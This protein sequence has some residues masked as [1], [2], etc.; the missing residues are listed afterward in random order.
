MPQA[1]DEAGNIWEVDAQGNAVRLVEP[2]PSQGQIYTLPQSAKEIAAETRQEARESRAERAEDRQASND[3][4][5][6]Q[7]KAIEIEMKRQELA[8]G[9]QSPAA[10]AEKRDRVSRL[11]Q[12]VGQ[13]NRVQELYD[14]SIGT[15]KG[16]EG[17]ADYLPLDDNKR[18]DAAGA[19]LSQQG[20]AAFRVPGTGTV[21]DRDA[22]MFDRANLPTASTRDAAIEEQLLGLRNRVEAEM[23]SLGLDAPQWE[24][25]PTEPETD[26]TS[27]RLTPWD[28]SN[29]PPGPDETIA[30][31]P[32]RNVRDDR[33]SA[34]IDAMINAGASE[35]T[36]NA[37][38]KQQGFASLPL[39][40]LSAAR[41]WMKQN[42]GKAYYGANATK[43]EDLPFLSRIAGSD[44][45][46]FA[47]N[48]ANSAT[49]GTAAALAGDQGR[50]AIDAMQAVNPNASL[51]GNIFG[52]IT[53][54]A[55]AE[56]ALGARL[57]GTAA[58]RFAPRIADA[59]YGGLYGFNEAD[60]GQGAEGALTGA[61]L[62]AAGGFLGDRAMRATGS[63]LRGVSDPAV[64][65]LRERGVPL[66]FGQAVG[67]S[68]TLGAMAKKLEDAATSLP[69][70][71]NTIDARRTEGLEAFNRALFDVG[72]ETTGS[73]VTDYGAAGVQQ[74]RR[75]VQ[76]AYRDALDPVTIDASD[77]DLVQDLGGAILAAQRIPNVNNAQDA[78]LAAMQSRID[79]AVDP[80]TD[81][82]SG[83]GFQEAYRG[84][85]RTRRERA[86][87]DYGHET[88]QVMRQSQD[89]LAA[90]L[91]RQNPGAFQG[92]VNA[93]AA[94]RRANIL[95]Q[96]LNPNAPD[97]LITPA[98][99]N[100]A[101]FNNASKLTGKIDAA[102]GNRPFYEIANAGQ[103]VLPSSVP[104]SGTADRAWT[105]L[106]LGGALGGGGGYLAGDTG[107]G[108]ATGLGATLAL[109]LGG[110]R[111]GQR[112]LTSAVT[113]RPALVRRL[114]EILAERAQLGGAF[115]AGV[116][117][118]LLVGSQ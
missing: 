100:R 44:L 67:N 43:K 94:N 80:A 56:L 108:T 54:A 65:Y 6:N 4:V 5:N 93:N 84:L 73:Q 38:L 14:T 32:T 41:Q 107:A 11:N 66:T 25:A 57:A 105:G 20:L 45:G 112:A 101:D 15:T 58:A 74:M 1:R 49:A 2:A 78:T 12:L 76:Q 98:Q 77:P 99:I 28:A 114:G 10:T 95:A 33:V 68:G 50:G 83:R 113:D 86:N 59:S 23:A 37:V 102:A 117:A 96:S 27:P 60:A 106:A 71:G 34:Q 36:I 26:D 13:I 21:S 82:I 115:G 97:E 40:S 29:G 88:G 61:A 46:S 81:T 85:A 109:M 7:L 53:G 17:L 118:P 110:S 63:A 89:A 52:G 75:A 55:G 90:A 31:G 51:A 103:S 16:V 87:T 69:G 19:A 92:F 48:Y 39:G 30:S 116:S 35:A 104:N 79:G 70:V 62:G 8:R 64:Q 111:T 72:S 42:P 18:F 91:E 3:A 47:A 9:G 24:T 22:I